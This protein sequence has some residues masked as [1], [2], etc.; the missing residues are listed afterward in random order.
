VTY[1]PAVVTGNGEAR[2][3]EPL[4]WKGSGDLRTLASANALIC[5]PAG[6]RRFEPG[7]TVEVAPF[8]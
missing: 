4:P 3:A 6:A 8:E 1:F 5:F 2:S 7:E